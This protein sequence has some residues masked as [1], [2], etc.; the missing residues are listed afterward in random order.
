MA[1]GAR[2]LLQACEQGLAFGP[3]PQH[4]GQPIIGKQV[5]KKWLL[6]DLRQFGDPWLG[7]CQPLPNVS[8]RREPRLR[9]QWALD[10]IRPIPLPQVTGRQR[11]PFQRP[12]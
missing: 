3:Q 5:S 9:R 6:A 12:C 2:Q 10:K 7:Q 1:Q 4:A 11:I 8:R